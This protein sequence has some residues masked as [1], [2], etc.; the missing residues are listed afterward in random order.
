MHAIMT[1]IFHRL[2]RANQSLRSLDKSSPRREGEALA[3][4]TNM[5][6]VIVEAQSNPIFQPS[7]ARQ[8][9]AARS[10]G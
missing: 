2:T 6:A 9:P 8:T 5:Q 7:T 3:S 4:V 10:I 1:S